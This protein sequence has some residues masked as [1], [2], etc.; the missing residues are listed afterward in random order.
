MALLRLPFLYTGQMLADSQSL[1]N[2]LVDKDWVK[3]TCKIGAISLAQCFSMYCEIRSG[4]LDFCSSSVESS[5]CIPDYEM[6]RVGMSGIALIVLLI[7]GIVDRF[8]F[9]NTN[10]K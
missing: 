8:S 5:C 3:I 10:W 7:V 1:G 6:E 9:V 4:P 2:E